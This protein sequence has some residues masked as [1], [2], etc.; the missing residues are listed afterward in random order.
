M[1]SQKDPLQEALSDPTLPAPVRQALSQ[2]LRL[3]RIVLDAEGQWWHEGEPIAH[4]RIIELFSRSIERTPGGTFVLHIGPFVYPIEVKD[5][6]YRVRRVIMGE[7][8]SL[9]IL[10]ELSDDSEEPLDLHSLRYERGR[11]FT[12]EVKKDRGGPF[13][14]R[15]SRPAYYALAE[16]IEEE[17]GCYVLALG[18][19]RILIAA[20]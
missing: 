18:E 17:G 5:T 16:H 8:A 1:T 7:A 4:P 20:A 3:E 2:G 10:V 9:P 6:P 19:Q 13:R 12:C 14:A 11:G 15:F